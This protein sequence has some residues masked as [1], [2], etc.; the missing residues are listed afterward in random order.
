MPVLCV[1]QDLRYGCASCHPGQQAQQSRLLLAPAHLLPCFHQTYPCPACP[2]PLPP[3]PPCLARR[4]AELE[5]SVQA[6][7]ADVAGLREM[8]ESVGEYRAKMDV[9]RWVLEGLKGLEG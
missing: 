7:T 5:R 8:G 1:Q 4:F 6:S 3:A 2:H 9:A